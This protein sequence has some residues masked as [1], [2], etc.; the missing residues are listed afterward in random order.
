[1]RYKI[2]IYYLRNESFVYEK[3]KDRFHTIISV[4]GESTI[5]TDEVGKALIVESERRGFI[6]IRELKTI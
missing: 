3:F 5:Y 6:K 1:M 2:R 4:N